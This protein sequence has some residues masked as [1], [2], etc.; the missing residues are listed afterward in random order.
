V[1]RDEGRAESYSPSTLCPNRLVLQF[2]LSSR[3]ARISKLKL[4]V[5]LKVLALALL[6]QGPI[7]A[8]AA[9]RYKGRVD[10][11]KFFVPLDTDRMEDD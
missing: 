6:D 10:E 9:L 5:S 11:G 8:I 4:R 1:S 7:Y 2:F 3:V